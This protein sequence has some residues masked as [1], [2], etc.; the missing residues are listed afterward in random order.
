MKSAHRHEQELQKQVNSL[1]A[2]L[3]HAKNEANETPTLKVELNKA[4]TELIKL[5]SELSATMNEAK[6]EAAEIIAL[7]NALSNKE[8]ELKQ[9][10]GQILCCTER[11]ATIQRASHTYGIRIEFC[12]K[13][14]GCAK[15]RF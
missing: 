8:D 11:F 6:S 12:S 5:K 1:Q 13:E 9:I 2:E 3:N 14:I 10:T 15:D 7:K 4:Q